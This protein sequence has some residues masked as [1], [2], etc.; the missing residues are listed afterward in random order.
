MSRFHVQHVTHCLRQLLG[1][2][3]VLDD[4]ASI[5]NTTHCQIA[6]G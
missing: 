6:K 4:D 3:V 5:T 1:L 2:I